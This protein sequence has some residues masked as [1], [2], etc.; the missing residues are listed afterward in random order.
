MDNRHH[1][2]DPR[3]AGD[4]FFLVSLALA[5]GTAHVAEEPRAP[6][7]EPVET[8]PDLQ[9]S[10]DVLHGWDARREAAWAASDA[11]RLRRLYTPGSSAG[12]ADVRLLRAYAARGLV[13]RRLETQVFAVR[14]LRTTPRRVTLR[15]FDRVAGGEV[16]S[17]G[18]TRPLPSTR[19]A[20]RDVTF[21]RLDGAWRVAEVSARG[22]GPRGSRR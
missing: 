14:A 6:S 16:D 4:M 11:D 19:P 20:V 17:G 8:R 9:R 5:L 7:V 15:V 21:R 18:T 2:L 22:R 1:G 13:V 3:Q 10:L 12:R